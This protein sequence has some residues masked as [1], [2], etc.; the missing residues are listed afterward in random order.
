MA[1]PITSNIS[2]LSNPNLIGIAK[3][4]LKEK[5]ASTKQTILSQVNKLKKQSEDL[6]KKRINV[7]KEYGTKFLKLQKDFNEGYI[8]EEEKNQKYQQFQTQKEEEL[9]LI[10]EEIQKTQNE[11]L[12]S[13]KDVLK[14]VK[15]KNKKL[16]N[17]IKRS[18]NTSQKDQ[19]RADVARNVKVLKNTAKDKIA[20]I[21]ISLLTNLV[22]R[23]VKKNSNL[24][25]LVDKT[26]AVIDA[27]DT[28]EKINQAR[29]LRNNALK[30]LNDQEA[31][32]TRIQNVIQTIQR[33]INILNTVIS[34][35]L[36]ILKLG[37]PIP[38]P[39]PIKIKL[40][41]ILQRIL[42]IIAELSIGL[43]IVNSVLIDIIFY[44][45]DLK[46]QLRNLGDLINAKLADPTIDTEQFLQNL[47]SQEQIE[48]SYKGFKFAI[49]EESGPNAVTVRGYKRK[50]AV[51]IDTNNVDVLKSELSFT[52]DPQDLIDTLKIIIDRE[53]LIA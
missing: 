37:S 25:E 48:T 44:L 14:N 53:N 21:V 16:T 28:Q 36:L 27:A 47:Q 43:A 22:I 13:S 24:Q 38:I 50:F 20:P 40:Q 42:K 51:A 33:I 7:E 39:L 32:I 19:R 23:I 35:I 1:N 52:Q 2:S 4:Q 12:N 15:D 34:I 3:S 41:P 45:Q 10:N 11:I 26:N 49:R 9:K 46:R 29:I 30:I 6:I 18:I 31:K 5:T 17:T 8:T